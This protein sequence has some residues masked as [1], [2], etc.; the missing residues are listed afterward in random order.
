M[1]SDAPEFP[2]AADAV[3]PLR[4]A[5]QAKNSGEFVPLWSGQAARLSVEIPAGE[6]TRHLLLPPASSSHALRR[7]NLHVV[8]CRRQEHRQQFNPNEL[9]FA[10]V[11]KNQLADRYPQH[12]R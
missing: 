12:S 7:Y 4:Q 1:A 5:A 11:R 9:G 10:P 6:L 3:M 2:L 8:M